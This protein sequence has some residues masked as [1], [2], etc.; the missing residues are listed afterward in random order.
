LDY[1]VIR[2]PRPYAEWSSTGSI[3]QPAVVICLAEFNNRS[4]NTGKDNTVSG[5]R[6]SAGDA[7]VVI[8]RAVS[9]VN[10]AM[11]T[12]A[13]VRWPP[14]IRFN[15]DTAIVVN[16]TICNPNI[17]KAAVAAMITSDG[18]SLL[19]I[20]ADIE[21]VDADIF[22]LFAFV[23]VCVEIDPA[24]ISI[25]FPAGTD[26]NQVLYLESCAVMGIKTVVGA[27]TDGCHS[28]A[29]GTDNNR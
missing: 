20:T 19:A 24:E 9:D 4:I 23:C 29:V 8:N 18:D 14:A 11:R 13:G 12:V 17:L 6:L 10:V 22:V 16:N 26:E 7:G 28:G 3:A 1:Q 2:F 5:M 21:V 25:Y 27:G 15:A